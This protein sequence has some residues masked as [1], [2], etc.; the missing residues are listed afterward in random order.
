MIRHI[1]L[2]EI[3]FSL[4]ALHIN[5]DIVLLTNNMSLHTIESVE[6]FVVSHPLLEGSKMILGTGNFIKNMNSTIRK[7]IVGDKSTGMT[8]QQLKVSF[9]I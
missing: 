7:I 3:K 2:D 4:V 9:T 5:M 6:F 1:P 8:N